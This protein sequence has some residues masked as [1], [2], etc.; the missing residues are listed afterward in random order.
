MVDSVLKEFMQ[1]ENRD[2]E[3]SAKLE[4]LSE[5]AKEK[6]KGP[7]GEDHMEEYIRLIGE[8]S[9][10]LPEDDIAVEEA[11]MMSVA[12]ILGEGL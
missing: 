9:S 11:S 3:T 4:R 10:I 5:L 8:L 6:I 2:P 7:M 1:T 12:E